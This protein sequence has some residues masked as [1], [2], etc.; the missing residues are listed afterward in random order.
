MYTGTHTVSKIN[1]RRKG[2]GID[3]EWT[4]RGDKVWTVKTN[5]KTLKNK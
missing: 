1:V 2:C 5:K 4:G 3:R